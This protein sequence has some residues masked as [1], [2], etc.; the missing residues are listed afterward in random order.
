MKKRK[1]KKV[2]K[3]IITFII[4]FIFIFSCTMQT[5]TEKKKDNPKDTTPPAAPFV[6]GPALTNDQTPTW[7][8][9]TPD[10]TV[11]F[12]YQLDA[13]NNGEWNEA[14]ITI[15][16]YTPDSDLTE[17]DHTLYV[18]ASDASGNWSASGS[19]T[20][21][22]DPTAPDAPEVNGV[23]PTNDAIPTWTWTIPDG[24][25]DIRYRLDRGS[26]N[27]IGDTTT[28]SFTPPSPL[29]EGIIH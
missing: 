23:T 13:E 20:I 7:T 29:S 27:V 15:T 19:F 18:Q 11:L 4:L 22:I 21:T 5:T 17:G 28:T 14:D 6:S 25:V 1:N 10:T 26:W 2:I 24:S 12:R 3:T 9:D 8:W 16:Q